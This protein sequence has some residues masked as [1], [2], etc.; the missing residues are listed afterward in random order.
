VEKKDVVLYSPNG[1]ACSELVEK[2]DIALIGCLLNAEVVGRA[3]V[4]IAEKTGR[5]VTLIAAG[6]Q[7]D[8]ENGERVMYERRPAWRIFAI[9]DYLGC[10]AILSFMSLAKS[11]EAAGC[12]LMF[13]ACRGI[14]KELMLDSF[15]GQ[16]LVKH[17][18]KKDVEHASRLNLYNTVPVIRD[19]RIEC[20]G[21]TDYT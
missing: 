13:N 15:S 16:Y 6:E 19:G 5:D 3:A 17:R 4:R 11:A 18:R 9:E 12:E 8:L 10:G 21:D 2:D 7:R 1:A 14:V 20:L